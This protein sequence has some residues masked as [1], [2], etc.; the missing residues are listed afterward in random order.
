MIEATGSLTSVELG[1]AIAMD[2]NGIQL[3]IIS[4]GPTLFPLGSSTIIWTAIDNN[5]NSAFAI[6]QVSIVDTTPP[7]ISFSS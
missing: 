5:G 1:E 4:N 3:L 7:T 2:E 6:Q